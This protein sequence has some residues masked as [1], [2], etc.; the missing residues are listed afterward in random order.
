[1]TFW[2][3]AGMSKKDKDFWKGLKE[4]D[5]MI[6]METWV[7]EKGWE[8]IRRRLPEGYKWGVQWVTRR[9]RKGKAIGGMI[10]GIRQELLEK[11]KEINVEREGSSGEVRRGEMED[12]WEDLCW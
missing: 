3:V 10:M 12:N 7:E 11:W 2:N 1:M 4:R 5:V 9:E 6:L 8:R